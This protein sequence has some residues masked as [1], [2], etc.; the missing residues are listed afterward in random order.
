[1]LRNFI[2]LLLIIFS[3]N[4]HANDSAR[5]KDKVVIITGAGKGIGVGISKVFAEEGAKLIISSRTKSDLEK[6]T[7]EINANGGEA[8]YV[9]GD[10]TKQDDM[11]RLVGKYGN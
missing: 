1:M 4:T 5:M 9:I 8:S 7:N 3:V 6:L 10:I 2:T 11:D